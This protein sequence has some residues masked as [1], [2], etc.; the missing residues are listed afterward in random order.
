MVLVLSGAHLRTPHLRAAG[1][2]PVQRGGDGE[3]DQP[4]EVGAAEVGDERPGVD[5]GGDERYLDEDADAVAEES[6][7]VEA[8]V[9]AP[10]EAK[11]SA[12]S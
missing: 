1:Q 11:R 6:D 10:S 7:G 8:A 12:S 4:G 5:A 2:R 9:A 3:T